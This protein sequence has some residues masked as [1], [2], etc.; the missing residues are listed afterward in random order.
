MI[1][2]I[3]GPAGAGKSTI[4]MALSQ[5]NP[6]IRCD[7][8][9]RWRQFIPIFCC[10]IILSLPVYLRKYR[11]KGHVLWLAL[12]RMAYLERLHS[13]LSRHRSN[14]DTVFLLDQGPVHRLAHLHEF[15]FNGIRN[16]SLEL[17][18]TRMLDDWA[19]TLD[20]IFWVDAQDEVLLERI[21][22]RSKWH[23]VKDLSE[24]EAREFLAIY[25]EAYRGVISGLTSDGGPKVLSFSTDQESLDQIVNKIL[26]VLDPGYGE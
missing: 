26:N 13:V 9:L 24:Q 1:A 8:R 11:D 6:A 10:K 12:R 19:S 16:Q 18:W 14:N 7:Y 2:E 17:W 21:L 5:R 23:R 3:V 4:T 20:L 15:G 25:R 22:T